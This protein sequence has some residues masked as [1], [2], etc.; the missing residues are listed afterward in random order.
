MGKW[1]VSYV[2]TYL[3]DAA[4]KRPTISLAVLLVS[5]LKIFIQESM[6]MSDDGDGEDDLQTSIRQIDCTT[7][8]GGSRG[9]S[10]YPE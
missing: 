7:T 1:Q 6:A 3:K 4:L 8:V 10:L 5:E 9:H 2:L